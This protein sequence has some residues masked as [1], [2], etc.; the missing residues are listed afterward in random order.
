[1][2]S[3]PPTS[4]HRPRR[5]LRNCA[6][7]LALDAVRTAGDLARL[8]SWLIDAMRERLA[9]LERHEQADCARDVVLHEHPTDAA[10]A[11]MMRANEADLIAFAYYGLPPRSRGS[12]VDTVSRS[13]AGYDERP[14]HC[15]V[16]GGPAYDR[17][18][19]WTH[20][21]AAA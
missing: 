12:A 2:K 18:R 19:C 10:V 4:T 8:A 11:D 14:A 7:A 13:L 16:C 17:S 1:V 20:R 6:L 15:V 21:G 3:A 9:D 5:A